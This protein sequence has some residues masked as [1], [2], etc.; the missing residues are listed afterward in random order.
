MKL[1]LAALFLVGLVASFL[2]SNIALGVV[3]FAGFAFLTQSYKLKGIFNFNI[4]IIGAC[5]NIR[6]EAAEMGAE[7]Y[8]FNMREKTGALDFITSPENGGVDASLIS[9]ENG[10]KIAT[11][12]ILYDQRTKDCEIS[13]D[14]D[15]NVCDSG[16]T[17]VRKQFITNISNCIKTP[18]R[19]Y[20][21]EDMVALCK[22]TATFMRERMIND[23][24]AAHVKLDKLLLQE[25]DNQIGVNYE[26]DGTT[27][28][29]GSYKDIQLITTSS[30][31]R[32]P[33][34][35]NWAEVML[36]YTNNQLTGVPAVIGQGNLQFFQKLHGW[37][38]CNSTTPY[39]EANI[40]DE[41]RFY[42]D[43][44][45]NSILG[46][47][48]FILASYRAVHLLTFNENR[49]IGINTPTAQHIVIPDPMGYPFDWN[50][51]F[52]FDS[53]NKVWKSQLSVTWGTFNRFQADSFAADGA[54]S[55]P[56][57]SPDCADPLI[58]MLGVFGY[59]ATSA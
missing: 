24:S 41:A 23:V 55:S 20:S 34:T 53:C 15:G 5:E 9:Y 52:Y 19:E 17:P 4:D 28:S 56:D 40:E 51:D 6:R 32:V 59:T 57:T 50:L 1:K 58:G 33:L 43:Q 12:K 11:L 7:N 2:L 14:C 13:T 39:G 26:F 46:A 16:S 31:Q 48:R 49:N 44:S 30:G 45:A 22:D 42:L 21:N 35:G 38:C 25:L 37:S 27:T 29:A 36:D 47:N 18:V 54:S 10:R 3:A 8:A